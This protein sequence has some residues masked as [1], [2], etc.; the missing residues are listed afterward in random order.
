MKKQPS[1]DVYFVAVKVFLRDKSGRLFIFKDRFG[2]WDLP[3]GRLLSSEFNTSLQK[4]AERK[5]KEE[6]GSSIKFVFRW[7][8]I[9][10]RHERNEIL[11]NGKKAKK[12]IFAI[13]YD[14]TYLKGEIELGKNHLE[15]KW[16]DIKTFKPKEYFTGGWL[17]G[18]EEYIQ[19]QKRPIG[20]G[21][22]ELQAILKKINKY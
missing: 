8:Q 4:V 1:K 18:V 22:A 3:G 15:S 20:Q 17:K 10:M 2:D 6:L 7:H 13:G 9:F 11:S 16:V 14:V 21:I 5:I 12:R 19:Y